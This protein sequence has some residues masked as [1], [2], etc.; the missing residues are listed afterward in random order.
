MIDGHTR[1]GVAAGDH[2]AIIWPLLCGMA[3][4]NYYLMLGEDVFGEEAERI[5]LVSIC[6][7]ERDLLAR[8]SE[9]ARRLAGGPMAA[10]QLTK[11]SLNHWLRAAE[12]IFE[13]S[14]GMQFLSF[15]G[16][17]VHEGLAHLAHE[18]QLDRIKPTSEPV[19]VKN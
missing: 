5:G 4:A 9:I 7:E 15:T 10:L 1:L 3:K 13:A 11:H 8:A 16:K 19:A 6:V 18:K 14:L 2:A 12:P 17:D